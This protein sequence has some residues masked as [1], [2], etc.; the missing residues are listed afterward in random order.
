MIW[1]QN[2]EVVSFTCGHSIIKRTSTV[3]VGELMLHYGGG[4]HTRVGTCQVPVSDYKRV[5]A[6]L[7]EALTAQEPA[8]S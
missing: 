2:R 5:K 4:G 1:G 6:E 3:N 7:L 8:Y